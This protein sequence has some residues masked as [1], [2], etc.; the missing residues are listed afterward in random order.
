MLRVKSY[1]SKRVTQGIFE[2]LSS[3][4]N[5]LL[6]VYQFIHHQIINLDNVLTSTS[7]V[8]GELMCRTLV[9]E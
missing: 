9:M 2:M 3:S 1:E 4:G 6:I 5:L 8:K 7:D